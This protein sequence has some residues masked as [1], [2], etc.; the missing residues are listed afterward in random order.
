MIV[1]HRG[2]HGFRIGKVFMMIR[3]RVFFR[4]LILS[5]VCAAAVAPFSVFPPA[6][7]GAEGQIRR[8]VFEGA[9][10]E[11]KWT[12]KE[13]DLPSDWSA[14]QYLVLEFRH[15]SPQRFFLFAYDQSGPRR[16]VIQ[17]YGQGV[18]IRASVPLKFFQRRDYGN[19][20]AAVNNRGTNSFWMS[21]WGPFGPINNVEALGITMEYPLH[22]PA[23]EIRAIRLSKEDPGS[24]ILEK[25]PVLDEFGQWIHADW[26]RKIKSLEQ[27]KK[28]WAEEEK[29]LQPGDFHQCQY[30]GYLN[31]KAKA[32]GFFRV[33]KIDGRWWFVDPDGHLYL[34]INLSGMTLGYPS[35]TENRKAYYAA[36]PPEGLLPSMPGLGVS[37][38]RAPFHAW[39]LL[40]RYGPDWRAKA[41]DMAIRRMEAWGL[42]TGPGL[43]AMAFGAADPS[44]KP[45]KPY[46]GYLRIPLEPTTS[47]LGLADVYSEEFPRRVDEAAAKQCAQ[48]K[49]DPYLVGYFV[50]NE[51]PW[52]GRESELVNM[53]LAG[54]ATAT[55]RELK[56]F[57]AGGDTAERRQ[58]FVHTAFEKYLQIAGEALRKNDP[59]HLNV[60]M[61]FGGQPPDYLIKMGRLFD[62]ISFNP[63]EYSPVEHVE[64]SYRLLDRPILFGEFQ[65]GVPENGLGGSLVQT[66]SQAERGIAYRY[67][68]EQAASHPAFVGASWFT[69]IDEPVI[70]TT[71][72]YNIGFIDVTDRPYPEMV[73][74]AI[75]T[76]K[77]LLGVHLGKEKPFNRKPLASEAG[78]PSYRLSDAF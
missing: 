58:A 22:K 29:A 12:I 65:F 69:A 10:S 76:H 57:L 15:S 62:V 11:H 28:E 56:A 9:R 6:V 72:N 36:L 42:T 50:G 16:V 7:D 53:I 41:D 47:F 4:T 13:L 64:R 27:L 21:V 60:G 37:T 43:E 30:G 1:P 49:N 20:M 17:P 35:P 34:S 40:R 73:Q 61:R 44:W 52:P 77:R 46:L 25:L 38:N 3:F 19:Q 54:P 63:Y 45:R 31:T 26:L 67:Y 5:V 32:T 24:E 39:N 48:R 71:E 14:Y 8:I 70:S 74:A 59:N 18:W 2:S 51:P 78:T 33:E 68:L 55:Q 66:A 23:L 75:A